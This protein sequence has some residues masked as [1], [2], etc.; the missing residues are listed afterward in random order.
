[1]VLPK[2]GL[3]LT[4]GL[5]TVLLTPVWQNSIRQDHAVTGMESALRPLHGYDW[6]KQKQKHHLKHKMDQIS[7]YL[8]RKVDEGD[9]GKNLYA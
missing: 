8:R 1:M 5:N 7:S 2:A 6:V 3:A 4:A 9:Q